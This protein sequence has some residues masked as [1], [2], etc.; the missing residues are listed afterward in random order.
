M[1]WTKSIVW[2]LAAGVVATA[3]VAGCGPAT[4]VAGPSM[5]LVV[6][7]RIAAAGRGQ[8]SYRAVGLVGGRPDAY[9]RRS[10]TYVQV[11]LAPGVDPGSAL[12]VKAC[13]AILDA[14]EGTVTDTGGSI[15]EV[16]PGQQHRQPRLLGA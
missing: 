12:S 1:G 6:S 15:S 13:L 2:A 9:T 8:D 3:I 14:V 11:T 4:P 10:F 7:D 16:I 5:S